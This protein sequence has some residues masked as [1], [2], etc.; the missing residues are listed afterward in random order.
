MVISSTSTL[1]KKGKVLLP[2][3]VAASEKA[4]RELAAGKLMWEL[5]S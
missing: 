2:T 4:V 1:T 5:P 3:S